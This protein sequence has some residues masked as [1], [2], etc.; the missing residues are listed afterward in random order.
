MDEL[1]K[2]ILAKRAH[3]LEGEMLARVLGLAVQDDLGEGQPIDPGPL[4]I[5]NL[6]RLG[7]GDEGSPEFEPARPL[8]T[9]D[10]TGSLLLSATIGA[11]KDRHDVP[12]LG[13]ASDNGCR[14]RRLGFRPGPLFWFS[15]S[16]FAGLLLRAAAIGVFATSRLRRRRFVV[17]YGRP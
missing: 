3:V 4:D 16:L 14:F 15:S 9:V 13:D 11:V 8:G 5:G 17:R 2:L 12:G 1:Q 7:D 10:D 6:M